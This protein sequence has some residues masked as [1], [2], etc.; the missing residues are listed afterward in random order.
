MKSVGIALLLV[1]GAMFGRPEASPSVTAAA[2]ISGIVWEDL[3]FDGVRQADEPGLKNVLMR[4]GRLDSLTGPDGSYSFE[5]LAP[6]SHV[7]T[8]ES[9]FI[10]TYPAKIISGPI[11]QAVTLADASIASLDFGVVTLTQGFQV[12]AWI[13]GEEV[14]DPWITA[15]VGDT[16]CGFPSPWIVPPPHSPPSTTYLYLLPPG[17]IPAC[18]AGATVSFNVNGLGT[19]ETIVYPSGLNTSGGFVPPG[20][21][22]SGAFALT[23]GPPFA[24]YRGSFPRKEVDGRLF[25]VPG[26]FRA[27]ID[28]VECSSPQ[29]NSGLAL[30][31]SVPSELIRAGCGVEGTLVEFYIGDVKANESILWKPGIDQ[32]LDLSF[33][34]YAFVDASAPPE[35]R[36]TSPT[37][38]PSIAPP[39]TGSA[40]L[41][42]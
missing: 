22:Q 40:G 19:N 17:I 42:H 7:V 41:A 32:Q 9:G 13:S 34:D 33:P 31:I 26:R 2:S 8:V 24:T 36:D 1:L 23:V 15:Y 14:Q 3:N 28:G 5:G 18:S 29:Y 20:N 12:T 4:A 39:D 25:V 16:Q 11:S 30:H 38:R 35:S 10:A 27:L 21:P 37:Q 6:G